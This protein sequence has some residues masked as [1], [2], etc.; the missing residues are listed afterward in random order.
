M[1]NSLSA[2]YTKKLYDYFKRKYKIKIF[3]TCVKDLS[4]INPSE[5]VQLK[6][7]VNVFFKDFGNESE[8]QLEKPYMKCMKTCKKQIYCHSAVGE[9]TVLGL[10]NDIVSVELE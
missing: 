2:K 6:N 3:D 7:E 10:N 4:D 9:Y 5:I 8:V 1:S